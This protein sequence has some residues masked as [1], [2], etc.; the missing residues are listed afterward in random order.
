MPVVGKI[1]RVP[2]FQL[3][4]VLPDCPSQYTDFGNTAHHFRKQCHYIKSYHY[5]VSR[6][7][8]RVPVDAHQA[9][10]EVHSPVYETD[11]LVSQYCEFHF[12]DEYHGVA[13]FPRVT[14]ELAREAAAGRPIRR[15]LDLGCATGRATFEGADLMWLDPKTAIIGRGLRTNAEAIDQITALLGGLSSAS[16]GTGD[17]GG[18]A[19]ERR[20]RRVQLLSRKVGPG[21]VGR[22]GRRTGRRRSWLGRKSGKNGDKSGWNQFRNRR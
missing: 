16:D 5:P 10:V 9:K 15:A 22:H 8:V 6:L 1:P 13:N 7:E 4:Q 14:A 20:G 12:G 19:R 18:P 17:E 2:A 21:N 11:D 3:N